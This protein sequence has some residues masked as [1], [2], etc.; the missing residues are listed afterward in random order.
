MKICVSASSNSL[1]AN[2]DSRFGRCPYFVVVN[3][4][5]MEFNVVLNDS[6]NAAHGAG[7]QAAQTV[8]NSGAKVVITG[9]VGPNAFKVL[10]AT[11]IKVITGVSGNIK[12]AVEKYKNGELEETSN[13]TVGGHFGMGKGA[14][15]GQ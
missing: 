12:E 2:V 11:G 15:K 6:T 9:N 10:S 7:I 5:T 3:S 8:V 14:S 13:P 1:D 4:E